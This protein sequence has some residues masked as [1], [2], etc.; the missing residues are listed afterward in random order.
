MDHAP[1][2]TRTWN[3]GYVALSSLIATLSAFVSL[4]LAGRAGRS[5]AHNR[6]FWL[7]AQAIVLGFGVWSMHFVGM[8]A[9]QASVPINFDTFLTALSGVVAVVFMLAGIVVMHSTG[10]AAMRVDAASSSVALPLIVLVVVAVTAAT[11]AFFLFSP[12][13]GAWAAR[14]GRILTFRVAAALV[15][16]VA[17]TGMHSTGRAA[18]RHTALPVECI[19]EGADVTLPGLVV[20]ILTFFVPGLAAT[21]VAMD[22]GDLGGGDP[23][24]GQNG[25]GEHASQAV[26]D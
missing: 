17:I 9:F 13:A 6:S 22:S 21:S 18:L 24:G 2:L 4:E 3:G 16:G 23:N 19:P 10:M 15:M 1:H 14:R 26:G 7:V 11:V 20:A 12:V 25:R 8:L 5:E